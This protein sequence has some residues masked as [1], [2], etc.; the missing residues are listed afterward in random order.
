MKKRS[1]ILIA[2]MLLAISSLS[3]QVNIE[4]LCAKTFQKFRDHPVLSFQF[5]LSQPNKVSTGA[6]TAELDWTGTT[7][8]PFKNFKMKIVDDRPFELYMLSGNVHYYNSRKD[9]MINGTILRS[10][11]LL[12]NQKVDQL[13]LLINCT[14]LLGSPQQLG[15]KLGSI[16]GDLQEIK[17]DV[18]G[19]KANL[20][21]DINDF[22]IKK[23]VLPGEQ[24]TIYEVM[25]YRWSHDITKIDWTLPDA[26]INE[27]F[28]VGGPKI[29]DDLSEVSFE[30]YDSKEIKLSQLKGNV[31]LLDF[32]GTWCRPCIAAMPKIQKLHE[33]FKDKGLIVLGP[34]YKEKGDPITLAEKK[35][36]TYQIVKGDPL[37]EFFA[38]NKTGV[39]L[40]FIID[41]NGFLVDYIV[42][43]Q[44][45]QGS[46][47]I[48]KVL[49]GLLKL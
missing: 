47:H 8:Y 33:Q 24:T 14:M 44:Q 18:D 2:G 22:E 10:G 46:E 37:E 11:G 25:T 26:T 21:I 1:T 30:T 27:E 9:K 38:L 34:T 32:W 20:W 29:G 35:E 39:P 4:S 13:G 23:I 15:A 41:Q 3:A 19:F 45:K 49:S 7:P 5:R 28:S 17:Y 48:N 36:I 43:D 6:I 31:I 42:G 40:L 16:D 12:F